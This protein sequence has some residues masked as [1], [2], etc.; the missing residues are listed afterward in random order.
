MSSSS[1][2]TSPTKAPPY[3]TMEARQTRDKQH[4]TPD[5]NR[6]V[7]VCIG[8]NS[9][10]TMSPGVEIPDDVQEG[11][12]VLIVSSSRDRE[13]W[14]LPKGGWETDESDE[15]AALR[16][17]W[18]EA[19]IIGKITKRLGEFK[20]SNSHFIY[21]QVEVQEVKDEYPEMGKRN[22]RW[23]TFD[24]AMKI[25]RKDMFKDMLRKSEILQSP[26]LS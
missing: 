15:E 11:Q 1:N 4:Y 2:L 17:G 24:E 21:F 20:D 3:H 6:Y 7:S 14:V 12:M 23:V 9:I 25:L 19:G 8:L 13:R 22:R 5:G 26:P 10:N 18:E 16:E